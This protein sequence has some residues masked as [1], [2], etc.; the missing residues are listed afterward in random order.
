VALAQALIAMKSDRKILVLDE[1]TSAL[2]AETEERILRNLE[3]WLV[4]QTVI[5]I[6]HRLA[7]LSKLAHRIVV[8]DKEGIVEQGTHAQLMIR[9]GWYADMV[10]LQTVGTTHKAPREAEHTGEIAEPALRY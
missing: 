7:T 5:I 10:R 6:A 3:P 1:F 9:G 4:N 8:L 2:D